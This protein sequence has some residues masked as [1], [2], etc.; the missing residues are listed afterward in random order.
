[1]EEVRRTTGDGQ[2]IGLEG[3]DGQKGLNAA[4][5]A[6]VPPPQVSTSQ[7][8]THAKWAKLMMMWCKSL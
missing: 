4:V 7:G 2:T 5:K 3:H 8:C 1:M 6:E